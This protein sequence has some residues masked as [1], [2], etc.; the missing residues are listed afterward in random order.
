[1]TQVTN[2]PPSDCPPR[3]LCL[4][5]GGSRLSRD[6]APANLLLKS[7]MSYR[8]RQR[9]ALTMRQPSPSFPR[10]GKPIILPTPKTPPIRVL[11]SWSDPRGCSGC[12]DRPSR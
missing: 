9:I 7:R 6:G 4:L 2:G 12:S 1:L 10:L 11:A 5:C 3:R 8:R